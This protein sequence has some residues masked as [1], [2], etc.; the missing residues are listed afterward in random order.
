MVFALSQ[1]GVLIL[2]TSVAIATAIVRQIPPVLAIECPSWH[3]KAESSF[4]ALDG[5]YKNNLRTSD[6]NQ[7]PETFPQLSLVLLWM[8]QRTLTH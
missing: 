6:I 3:G 7:S 1:R 8:P 4:C 2:D 5:M